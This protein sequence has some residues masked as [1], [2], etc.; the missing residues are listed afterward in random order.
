VDDFSDSDLKM[1]QKG[2]ENTFWAF[3]GKNRDE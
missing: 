3:F 1:G 2:T